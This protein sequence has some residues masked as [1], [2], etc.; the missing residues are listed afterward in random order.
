M[1]RWIEALPVD[2]AEFMSAKDLSDRDLAEFATGDG[3][4]ADKMLTAADMAPCKVCGGE[5][6]IVYGRLFH[7]ETPAWHGS[8]R[9]DSVHRSGGGCYEGNPGRNAGSHLCDRCF[10]NGV[11]CQFAIREWNGTSK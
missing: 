9:A 1:T 10:Q 4:D 6:E 5:G 7:H 3:A 8:C 11:P 2:A